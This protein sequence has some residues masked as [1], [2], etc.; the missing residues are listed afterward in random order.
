MTWKNAAMAHA[1]EQDPKESCGLLIEIKG[2]EKYFP[3][4]NLSNWSNQCFI[5]VYKIT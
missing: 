3:C 2:K 5:I 1:K 4:K